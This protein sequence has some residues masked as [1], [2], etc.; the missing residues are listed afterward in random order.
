MSGWGRR[1]ARHRRPRGSQVPLRPTD[2][3][4]GQHHDRNRAEYARLARPFR[5]RSG[6]RGG[7]C[8]RPRP[9]R[10][11]GAA[12]SG[13]AHVNG[14]SAPLRSAAADDPGPSTLAQADS[15]RPFAA[16]P[17][18]RPA[19][20][21]ARHRRGPTDSGLAA[22]RQRGDLIHSRILRSLR[23]LRMA[24]KM[25]P[26]SRATVRGRGPNSP[27]PDRTG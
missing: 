24:V 5:R 10:R 27:I 23:C 21:K 17:D 22:V 16:P 2:D 19:P 26:A 7:P 9:C 4:A 11:R 6:D 14:A 18:R 13:W 3:P 20:T 8:R 1:S 12:R 15:G 25:A